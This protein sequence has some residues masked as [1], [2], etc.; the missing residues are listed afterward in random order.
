M[1][2]IGSKG[3]V[4]RLNPSHPSLHK[5]SRYSYGLSPLARSVPALALKRAVS[6]VPI[7]FTETE[8]STV[9][10]LI[11]T[12]HKIIAESFSATVIFFLTLENYSDNIS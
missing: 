1:E 5:I 6:R 2:T 12:I 7:N 9:N 3:K 4:Q 8:N 10:L 11:K